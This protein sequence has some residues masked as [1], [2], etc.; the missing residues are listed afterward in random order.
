MP[1]SFAAPFRASVDGCK[2]GILLLFIHTDAFK[3]L[4]R[5]AVRAYGCPSIL[6]RDCRPPAV[7][8]PAPG[9]YPLFPV[10]VFH[11]ASA[12]LPSAASLLRNIRPADAR[13]WLPFLF[14]RQKYLP[15]NAR[16]VY[17]PVQPFFR[18]VTRKQASPAFHPPGNSRASPAALSAYAR[19]R[20][21]SSK[22]KLR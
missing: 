19:S 5:S 13:H 21:A 1:S 11:S 16:T 3:R 14:C 4:P 2:D 6:P 17:A 9:A 7:S 18:F 10:R 20:N 8:L 22:P 12:S 15:S